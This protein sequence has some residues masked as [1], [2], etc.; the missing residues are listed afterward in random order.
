MTIPYDPSIASDAPVVR[1][2]VPSGNYN[3][4][5]K[6][7]KVNDNNEYE[8]DWDVYHNNEVVYLRQWLQ[9]T[10]PFHVHHL[11]NI[12]RLVGQIDR[13]QSGSFDPVVAVGRN[14][15]IRIT[16]KPS[17]NNP[18]S[19]RNWVDEIVLPPAG[20]TPPPP[21]PPAQPTEEIPF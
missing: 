4:T 8:I 5:F 12:A 17:K 11:K 15:Q 18:G 3:A 7:V 20:E 6:S 16:K 19:F 14:F 21:P 13:F 10:K 1:P 9:M 2:V